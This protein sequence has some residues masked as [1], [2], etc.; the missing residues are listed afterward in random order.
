MQE[1]PALTLILTCTSIAEAYGCA[2][3]LV[4][5]MGRSPSMTELPD[6]GWYML[7]T[8]ICCLAGGIVAG[9]AEHFLTARPPWPNMLSWTTR[10]FAGMATLTTC[11]FVLIG[12][13]R[14]W[15][16]PNWPETWPFA[17]LIAAE[18]IVFFQDRMPLTYL[19]LAA[20]ALVTWRTHLLGAAVGIITILST[21]TFA[22]LSG[23]GPFANMP[24]T[25]TE[26][27]LALQ[28]FAA[29]CFYVSVPV[30]AQM[31]RSRRLQAQLGEALITVRDSEARYRLIAD[32][33]SDIV[34]Q[35][36]VQ[37]RIQY[38]S[39]SC[40]VLGYTPEELIGRDRSEFIHV[41][42]VPRLHD[43]MALLRS[44]VLD[45]RRDRT[46]RIRL[47]GGG[48]RWY[49]GVPNPITD[50]NGVLIGVVNVMRDVHEAKAAEEVLAASEAR[51]RLLAD[52][53]GDVVACYGRDGIL[54]FV[55]GATKATL[56]Y[57]PAELVGRDIN[58][59]IHPDD[60]K[61]AAPLFERKIADGPGAPA[62][63]FEYRMVRKDGSLVWLEAHPR[64]HYDADG[65]FIEWQ[66]VV[67]DIGEH[68]ALEERLL[69]ARRDADAA[70]K[71]KAEFLADMSHE[72]RGPLTTIMSFARLARSRQGVVAS[73][74][75][76][77]QRIEDASVDLIGMVNDILDFSRL[78]AAE[79]VFR[80]RPVA[81]SEP[82][83]AALAFLEPQARAKDLELVLIDRTPAGLI[84]SMDD[85]RVRQVLL[86]LLGNAVKFTHAGRVALQ[87]DYNSETQRLS[88][89][90]RDTGPGIPAD[91][92]GRLFHR[93]TQVSDDGVRA[94]AGAGLGLAISKGIVEGLGGEI[95]A[96]SKVG[97]GSCFSF[98][99]PAPPAS[100]PAEV[101]D[102][103]AP[104][105]R[106]LVAD[107]DVDT[108]E[109]VARALAPLRVEVLYAADGEAALKLAAREPVDL[110]VT[111]LELAKISGHAALRRLRSQ[112]GRN[113]ATP[114]LAL[115]HTTDE[116]L[117]AQ[118]ME[119]GFHGLLAKPFSPPELVSAIAHALAV[120]G[121]TGMFNGLAVEY[122][123]R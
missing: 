55:S 99:I 20:L 40:R 49:D 6:L 94:Y 106:I 15:R 56:G 69:G 68:K 61:V 1:S 87:V 54:T 60:A 122:V 70:T 24:G 81:V 36:D 75:T 7:I 9:Y 52:N 45:R 111:N 30:A 33:M 13:R 57:E 65:C 73:V 4:R 67:R 41:D 53:M 96:E 25:I 109:L 63:R 110:I 32:S 42:E 71:T 102:E 92:V 66:D 113:A 89:E 17:L 31:G 103:T 101:A 79:V 43:N 29:V 91:R 97:R 2:W 38:V 78:E 12:R 104:R 90:V 16:L 76:Y 21:A 80:S 84:V 117:F 3:L 118:V 37:G 22:T 19:I 119:E 108:H 115:A 44:G 27:L 120:G 10:D 98:W 83:R 114:V 28:L 64:A 26:R 59:M 14:E 23:H 86:N 123:P 74:R 47:K 48:Y 77:L 11:L 62:F 18:A 72:L 105:F 116:A 95:R 82:A 35:L 121:E 58:A 34:V 5:K 85:G 112:R 93:F 46:H 51:Y 50:E 100:E 8:A 88:A 39:P 107:G